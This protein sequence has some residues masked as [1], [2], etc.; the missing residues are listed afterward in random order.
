[1]IMDSFSG[2]R[3]QASFFDGILFLLVVVFSVSL[4]FVTLN[5]YTAAQDKALRSAYLVNY[6]QSA[7]KSLYYLD[8]TTLKDIPNYCQDPGL[9]EG[10][11]K[12]FCDGIADPFPMNC[13]GTPENP[14]LEAY[15][16]QVTVA[17]LLKKDVSS[18]KGGL[19]GSGEDA[20]FSKGS[21]TFLDDYYG[22]SQQFG[23]TALRCAMKELMKPFTF[24][25]YHYVAE[26]AYTSGSGGQTVDNPITPKT[27]ENDFGYASDAM[28]FPEFAP[29]RTGTG[30][31]G[32]VPDFGCG[33]VASSQLLVLRSP[34]KIILG[35][36]SA[37]DPAKSRIPLNGFEEKNLAFRICLWPAENQ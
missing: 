18:T 36:T 25:A 27:Q 20:T 7:A 21:G 34:F 23:R 31:G 1:M 19:T 13:L 16:N 3:G 10:T 15:P 6:L 8:V 9:G 2:K 28:Y 35:V 22:Q 29:Y 11:K 37:G 5:A 33:K 26:V 17:D 14:R 4:V 32:T 30:V 24:S 12:P